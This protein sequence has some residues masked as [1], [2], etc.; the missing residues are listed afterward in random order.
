MRRRT[1]LK[2][3]GLASAVVAGGGAL[4]LAGTPAPVRGFADIPAAQDWLQ[5]LLTAAEPRSTTAWALP[6]VLE[7]CAQSVEF[8]LHGF[9]E[10]KPAWFQSSLGT[11]AFAT[12]RRRGQ[13]AHGT[14]EPIPGAP[15]LIETSL[16]NAVARLDAA[17]AAF[18]AHA[19]PL[20]PHFA[21][22]ALGHADYERA[23]LMHIAEHAAETNFGW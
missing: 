14:T 15:A 17:L 2:A 3:T 19:G 12:F 10:A 5:Q 18:A 16:A 1:F 22:G 4:W 9:P 7:H 11:L 21:Y 6:Q 20:R 8:S 13:M 23:H